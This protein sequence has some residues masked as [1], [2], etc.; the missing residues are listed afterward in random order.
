LADEIKTTDEE[1]LKDRVIFLEEEFNEKSCNKAKRQLLYLLGKD[2]NAPITIYIS[3]FGGGVH[4]FL[5]LY[6]ILKTVKCRVTTVALGKCMS[7]G[8]YLL[9]CGDER[10]AY[11]TTRIMMHELAY[12]GS[13]AKLHDK[14][15]SHKE[16]VELQKILNELVSKKTKIKKPE[17]FLKEDKYLSLEDAL[18]LEVIT[19]IIE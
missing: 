18:K 16:A 3:S 4:D 9:L 13:Y 7:A 17:E 5:M 10:L 1:F 2:S 12:T 14:D 15:I 11:P 19:K 8:S 6:G